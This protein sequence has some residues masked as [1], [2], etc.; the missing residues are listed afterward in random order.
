MGMVNYNGH[1]LAMPEIING[2]N[3]RQAFGIPQERTMYAM[4]TTG[5][6]KVI[7]DQ[8]KIN[9]AQ[10]RDVGDVPHTEKG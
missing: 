4:D 10:I 8:D 6:S 7:S 5:N 3:L 9:T 2:K 1:A